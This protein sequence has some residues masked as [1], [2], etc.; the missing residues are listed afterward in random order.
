MHSPTPHPS[1]LRRLGLVS[2][3]ALAS[4]AAPQTAQPSCPVRP[5]EV[6]VTVAAAPRALPEDAILYRYD[7][8]APGDWF[9]YTVAGL[10]DVSGDGIPDFAVGAHQNQ[11]W[12]VRPA[13]DAPPGY[14]HVYSGADGERLYTL[15]SSGSAQVDGSDDHFGAAISSIEDLDGDGAREILVGAYLYDADDGDDESVDENTGGLFLFS[16]LSGELMHVIGGLEWGDRLAWAV[17]SIDDLDGDGARDLLVGV[18]KAD[19]SIE[20]LNQGSIQVFSSRTFERLSS[21]FGPGFEAHL[22]CSVTP[23]ADVDGDGRADYAGGAFMRTKLVEDEELQ[24]IGHA[25][26]FSSSTGEVLFAWDGDAANDHLGFS[27]T[28]LGDLD[29]DGADELAVGAM[30]SGW[31]GDYHGRGYVRVFSTGDGSLVATLVGGAHGDQFG[32]AL[33]A[34]G[35]RDGDGRTDLLVGAPSA[36]SV[37]R[38]ASS[39]R[40]GSVHLYSGADR[41]PL[42]AIA[43][44]ALDDQFG[45]S[46]ADLGDLDGDGFSEILVGAP[47][48][49]PDQTRPGYAVVISGRAFARP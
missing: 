25:A 35:D 32:W 43:G 17:T 18:E 12:G 41:T 29:G 15:H 13:P 5:A 8:D 20:V 36:I 6:R 30:Q 2:A 27:I 37:Q 34:A 46:V 45:A 11:N 21:V 1:L 26:V 28:N 47:E 40:T 14:V 38:D 3:L 39:G 33:A 10:G 31:V 44:L 22:G 9:G 24:Q 16:G 49:V 23:V 48:N 7:G 42:A 19:T 4:C